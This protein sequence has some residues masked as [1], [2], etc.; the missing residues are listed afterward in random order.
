[1]GTSPSHSTWREGVTSVQVCLSPMYGL[2]FYAFECVCATGRMEAIHSVQNPSPACS[3]LIRTRQCDWL[4]REQPARTCL[5]VHTQRLCP[6]VLQICKLASLMHL[7]VC[8]C[9]LCVDTC[10]R[11]RASVNICVHKIFRL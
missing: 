7:K 6:H 5:Y 2:C 11:S 8:L 10:T 1:M 3:A 9:A 4:R